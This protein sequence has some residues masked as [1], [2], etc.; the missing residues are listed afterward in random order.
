VLLRLVKILVSATLIGVLVWNIDWAEFITDFSGMD[1][2]LV[3]I[4][5]ILLWI[6]YPLSA[7]KWRKSLNLHGIDYPVGYLLRVHCIAFFFN[8]FLPTSI[9]GDAY[10]SFRT[11]DGAER[12]AH[13]ISAV[14]MERII[15]LVA[16]VFLGYVS[17]IYLLAY[18]T[19]VHPLWVRGAVIAGFVGILGLW[20]FW[21]TGSHEKLWTRL[22][23]IHKLEPLID[24]IRVINANSR[25]FPGLIVQSV[26]YQAV[27]IYTV[28]LLFASVDL[29][30]KIAESGFTAATAGVASMLPISINGIGVV[31]SSFVVAA[32]E[33]GLPY[34]EAL[35]V[36]LFLRAFMFLASIAFGVL[37]A[38][39][40]AETRIP[41]EKAAG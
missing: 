41:D 28:S 19:L 16:L 21:K 33:T 5:F 9:G 14:V 10:R 26:L 11:V 35:L 31:E 38:L 34:E 37:Y 15:G 24:S 13:A 17:A 2:L 8:N 27:A 30:G 1:P 22:K 29:P 3:A 36:T 6:Q 20:I 23:R 25:H 39:E 40:P 32:L 4:A 12:P 18:G 7:V